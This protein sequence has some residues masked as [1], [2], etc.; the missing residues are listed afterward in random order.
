MKN[1]HGNRP[2]TRPVDAKHVTM[3]GKRVVV[4][5]ET[6]FNR[7]M[8]SADLWEPTKPAPDADGNY[9]AVEAVLYLTAIDII[10][11][12]RRLG[13]TQAALARRA[14]IR[15]ETLN[16]IESGERRPIAVRAIE[17]I[18]Q[19]LAE[20]GAESARHPGNGVRARKK[21]AKAPP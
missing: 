9:P 17:K 16:R 3:K 19:A 2:A 10:R 8:R 1:K 12:R 14:G 6:E 15:L 13:L 18:E 5:E 20:V 21:A 4:L 7:I 11:R